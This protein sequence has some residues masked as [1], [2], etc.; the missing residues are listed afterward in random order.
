MH[1]CS[2]VALMLAHKWFSIAD[3]NDIELIQT[4]GGPAKVAELLG[5]E[6]QGGVQRVFNWLSRG[7]PAKVKVERP[8]LLM[9][10]L[11]PAKDRPK[12]ST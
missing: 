3:M 2:D 8:D 12:A 5:I 4:L 11:R 10:H 9:P 6:K 7:I 1:F